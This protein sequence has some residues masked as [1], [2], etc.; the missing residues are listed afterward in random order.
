MLFS[1]TRTV[2]DLTLSPKLTLRTLP[3]RTNSVKSPSA[4]VP[5]LIEVYGLDIDDL[6]KEGDFFS[7]TIIFLVTKT[8][9]L[10]ARLYQ[11]S[12]WRR[13]LEYMDTGLGGGCGVV[14]SFGLLWDGCGG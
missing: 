14:E 5:G 9:R 13:A 3:T 12:G 8:G 7:Q 2:G 4:L 10:L 1:P 11:H 6:S